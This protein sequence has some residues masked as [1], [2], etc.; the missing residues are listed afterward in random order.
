MNCYEIIKWYYGDTRAKRSQV[1][2]MQH[3]DHG[4]IILNK[5]G[6]TNMVK[7]AY[8]LHPIFQSDFD[9]MENFDLTTKYNINSNVMTLV[10]E[11][12]SVANEYLSHR[13]V[14]NLSEIRLSPLKEVNLML[15]AD[16]QQNFS[17][18]LIHHYGNHE[19]SDELFTYFSNWLQRL[20]SWT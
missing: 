19:R 20:K 6:V 9:L 18:F 3:I 14:T 15:L 17:D 10:M 11:Y 12:R 16:K 8:C 1:P 13:K 2:Y 7:D 4:L 5:L